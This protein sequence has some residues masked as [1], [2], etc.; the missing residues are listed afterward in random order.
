MAKVGAGDPRWIVSERDDGTN[1]G[2]WHWTET[3]IMPWVKQT[4]PDYFKNKEFC[5]GVRVTQVGEPK[6]EANVNTRKGKVFHIY[7]F[8]L[9][10]TWKG[11]FEG[12]KVS[13]TIN[14][15][16][17]SF[18]SDYSD[19]ESD[20]SIQKCPSQL[21]Y[22]LKQFIR[23]EGMPTILDTLGQ[24]L[25]L[26]KAHKGGLKEGGG[27]KPLSGSMEPVKLSPVPPSSP[28]QLPPTTPS[29]LPPSTLATRDIDFKVKFNA[30][31]SDIY[32]AL[33]DSRRVEAYTQSSVSL[34]P[35][36]GGVFSF[37]GGNI[38]GKFIDL[39]PGTFIKQSW[40]K[41]DWPE[42]HYSTVTMNIEDSN[43]GCLLELKHEQ[44]PADDSERTHEAWQ[45]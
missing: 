5:R 1:V 20:I 43:G 24:F 39:K 16:E 12:E 10:L 15:P 29:S 40:R 34:D 28:L 45:L 21:S 38:A 3:N 37:Y 6:G 26:L 18:D 35:V 11:E 36:P 41:S 4:L 33:M 32:E 22:G 27:T 30:R 7:E 23:K 14:F 25:D 13:G 31:A 17:I 19:I 44:I 8:E 2:N 9:K 42:G